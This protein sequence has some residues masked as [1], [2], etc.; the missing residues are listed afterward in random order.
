MT[1]T[2][3][4]TIID[5]IS[6]T[7]DDASRDT[8]FPT[9]TAGQRVQ[10]V[11][12]QGPEIYTGT[13]W[14]AD[15]PSFPT[16]AGEPTVVLNR[17][18]VGHAWR[19]G[20]D[21]TGVADSTTAFRAMAAARD[22]FLCETEIPPGSYLVSGTT[23][24]RTDGT[25]IKTGGIR[26]TK[27]TFTPSPSQFTTGLGSVKG[28]SGVL[29]F[30]VRDV[31]RRVYM[32][33]R[34]I[35]GTS[36]YVLTTDPVDSANPLSPIVGGVALGVHAT[37]N[38][39]TGI[40]TFDGSLANEICNG[41]NLSISSVG[42]TV[43]AFN[44]TTQC[45]L[46]QTSGGGAPTFTAGSSVSANRH[47]ASFEAVTGP[48]TFNPTTWIIP[49]TEV[50]RFEKADQKSLI[51]Y[52]RM[53][54]ATYFGGDST[55]QKVTVSFYDSSKCTADAFYCESA[56]P[57]WTGNG[58]AGANHSLN[59]PSIA[60]RI[61]GR[62]F[63]MTGPLV[64][65]ADRGVHCRALTGSENTSVDH[66]ALRDILI[67]IQVPAE[68]AV[69]IDPDAA[70]GVVTIDG[71]S[72]N[73]GQGAVWKKPNSGASGVIGVATIARLRYEQPAIFTGQSIRW[74][75]STNC[76][77]IRDTDLGGAGVAGG[78]ANGG[79]YLR[80][81]TGVTFDNVLYT[82]A[83]GWDGTSASALGVGTVTATAGAAVFTAPQVQ[84]VV[85]SLVKV[86]ATTYNVTA[87]ADTT[88]ATISGAPTFAASAFY[89]DPLRNFLDVDST[90]EDLHF[91][92][93]RVSAKALTNIGATFETSL[94][95]P[96]TDSGAPISPNCHF[97]RTGAA[98]DGPAIM[99]CGLPFWQ[100]RTSLAYGGVLQ[101]PLSLSGA[102]TGAFVEIKARSAAVV[103][104]ISSLT[105]SGTTATATIPAGHGMTTGQVARVVVSGATGAN[106]AN[107]N[108][109]GAFWTM[110]Y[111]SPTTLTFTVTAGW[112]ASGACT[113]TIAAFRAGWKGDWCPEGVDRAVLYGS[114]LDNNTVVDW[115]VCLGYGV[116]GNNLQI[117]NAQ[118]FPN[119][120][121]A[122]RSTS[123]I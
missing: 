26:N 18:P 115:N 29:H 94:A 24:I 75:G 40:T 20:A 2:L 25:W 71:L 108:N 13:A 12:R 19:Y 31:I 118:H 59:T 34:I 37:Y 80:N 66:L 47:T 32:G 97:Y 122:V 60:L 102:S 48:T 63:P 39:G 23:R 35:V 123:W 17:W 87:V 90:C 89:R 78:D 33:D 45:V 107:W 72:A 84:M 53:G 62:E 76:L 57:G 77:K 46:A 116:G 109:G 30:L 101:L 86:G 65:S 14:V 88:H 111:A 27:I 56:G 69:V 52:C 96:K 51:G 58:S 28:I 106:A 11:A 120:T 82:G 114:F 54:G 105:S 99:L 22:L 104:S 42:Y 121:V 112:A 68:F 9:P 3:I 73:G 15:F 7:L 55:N 98:G 119:V 100:K 74:E 41:S 110:T 70:G 10:N 21:P 81:C 83:A 38:S 50:F 79:A 95:M 117:T 91:I 113:G 5:Q 1:K 103:F 61:T 93:T 67:G 49:D 16:L 8:A 64:A 36:H 4:P 85:G 43:S 6:R 44:G 92:G